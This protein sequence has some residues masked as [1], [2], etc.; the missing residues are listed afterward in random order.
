[1]IRDSDSLALGLR[2]SRR[3]F[4]G[5][6][7]IGACAA[8]PLAVAFTSPLQEPAMPSHLIAHS[9]LLDVVCINNRIVAVGVRGT[10]MFSDDRGESWTQAKVPL[11]TDLVAMAFSGTEQGWAVGHGGVVLHSEDGGRSWNKQLDGTAA[12]KLAIEYYEANPSSLP[13][14]QQF[15]DRERSLAIEG[16][17]QPFMDVFFIDELR[18]YVVGTFNR[19]FMTEDGG[20]NW[21]P[22]MHLTEN[23]GELHF[24]SV[25]GFGDQLYLAGEQGKVWRHDPTSDRFVAMDTSYTGTL[26]GVLPSSMNLL[27]AYGMRGSLYRSI[28][29]GATWERVDTPLQ[30]GITTALAMAED[31]FLIA[32][33]SGAVALSV[34]GGRHFK[35]LN[36]A[37]PMAYAGASVLSDSAVVMVGALGVRIETV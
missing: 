13:D 1:M 34:D 8:S 4:L 7:I 25:A 37:K 14:A 24:Y 22:L 29:R 12:S 21:Q 11:S 16:E 19:I 2:L 36:V 30:S 5:A 31:R 15:L 23:P 17:T 33:Q 20:R 32:D 18:G 3:S 9:P 35:K 27:L 10:V 28:D 26:F 6:A